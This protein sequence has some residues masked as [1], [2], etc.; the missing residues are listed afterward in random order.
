MKIALMGFGKMGQTID[1]LIKKNYSRTHEV[2]L[3]SNSVNAHSFSTDALS[4]VD[5]AIDFSEPKAAVPNIEK[6]FNANTP[7]VVGTTGWY[8]KL[9]YVKELC[10]SKNQSV[11]YASNFSIGMNIF[12][13]LNKQLAAKMNDY[14]AYNVKIEETHHTE[15]KDS[16]SGTAITLAEDVIWHMKRKDKWVNGNQYDDE[17]IG[18]KSNRLEDVKGIHSV[19]YI[20]KI[21]D[22]EIKH[23]AHSREG[24]ADGAIKA[25]EWLKDRKGIF[26][27]KDMLGF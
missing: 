19:Q 11:L 13:Y 6:A 22:I 15:K 7:I 8:G 1:E 12:F 26:T 5:V 9:N 23:T 4:E 27:M 24:F 20:S 21:D 10:Q 17:E 25:A 16:P 18:I 14:T 3:R 2:V